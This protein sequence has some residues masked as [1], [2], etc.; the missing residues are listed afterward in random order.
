[1]RGARVD[2]HRRAGRR[3]VHARSGL[4]VAARVRAW[5][6]L[7]LFLSAGTSLPSVDALLFHLHPDQVSGRVHVEPAG[8]CTGHAEHCTLGRTPPGSRAVAEL[9]L[10]VRFAPN[11]RRASRQLPPAPA[12][13]GLAA[14]PSLPRAPPIDAA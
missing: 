14:S 4:T 12:F 3:V 2:G 10:V 11:L 8:G 1:M 13:D 5:L 9:A 6:L 7:A